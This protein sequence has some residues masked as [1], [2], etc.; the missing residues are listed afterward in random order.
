VPLRAILEN[1]YG[2]VFE[3]EDIPK[4]EA[5]YEAALLKL[6]VIDRMGTKAL[7]VAKLIIG[8]AKAGERDPNKLADRAA[9]ML[10]K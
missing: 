4:L 2:P 5:A 8:L 1:E 9:K 7:T 6:G 3:P 10:R